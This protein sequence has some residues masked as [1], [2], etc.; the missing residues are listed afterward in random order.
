MRCLQV[1]CNRVTQLMMQCMS[2]ATRTLQKKV[3][4]FV[5]FCLFLM[6]QLSTLHKSPSESMTDNL[7]NSKILAFSATTNI[8]LYVLFCL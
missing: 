4:H 5:L 3:S 6:L 8:F 2:V 1:E 7:C